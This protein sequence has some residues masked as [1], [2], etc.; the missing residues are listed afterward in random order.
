MASL[1]EK[2]KSNGK[3]KPLDS[4]S[5]ERVLLS[6]QCGKIAYE[7]IAD[8]GNGPQIQKRFFSHRKGQK[9]PNG[10]TQSV[11]F[12]KI[13]WLGFLQVLSDAFLPEGYPDSVSEDYLTYQFWDTL[14]ALCSSITGQ[15]STL[16]ILESVLVPLRAFA[17]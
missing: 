14:Q 17:Y 6:E 2:R 10:G 1:P 12:W 16:A 9:N 3:A 15:L 7:Y 13:W 4:S 11:P 8:G 5:S